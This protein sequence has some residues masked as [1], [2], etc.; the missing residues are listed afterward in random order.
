V[1]HK[2]YIFGDETMKIIKNM[3]DERFELAALIF[4]LAGHYEYSFTRNDYQK[5]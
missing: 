3:V 4:R 1:A 2:T 5:K